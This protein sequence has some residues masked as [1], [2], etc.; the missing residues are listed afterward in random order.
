[1]KALK[2]D[3][4]QQELR[5]LAHIAGDRNLIDAFLQNKDVHLDTANKVFNLGIPEGCLIETHPDYAKYKK[6]FKKQRT[7]IKPTNFGIAYGKY[8]KFNDAWFKTYPQVK[9]AIARCEQF[10]EDSGYTVTWA[11]RRRY[12]ITLTPHDL[13]SGFN[14]LIQGTGADMMKKAAGEIWRWLRANAKAVRIVLLIHDEIILVGPYADL[15]RIK[16]AVEQIMI[17][18]MKLCVPLA[19]DSKIV[20]NH[21]E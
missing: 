18:T 7:D 17:N 6:K 3:Y 20:S 4:N 9:I 5:I 8:T 10:Q 11:G 12:Y 15:V 13:R 14:M 2:I 1:V 21:G 19:V 16:P